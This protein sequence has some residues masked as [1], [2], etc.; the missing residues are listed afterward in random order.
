MYAI[1]RRW[2]RQ[3]EPTQ[4]GCSQIEDRPGLLWA[5][6]PATRK[7]QHAWSRGRL[8][9]RATVKRMS[10]SVTLRAK[11]LAVQARRQRV[12]VS[13]TA[14]DDAGESVSKGGAQERSWP[15]HECTGRSLCLWPTGARLT[16]RFGTAF[17]LR[18][19]VRSALGTSRRT[20]VE[21]AVRQTTAQG[22]HARLP[23]A[24]TTQ[25]NP[26]SDRQ[27]ARRASKRITEHR[28]GICACKLSVHAG[29]L[30]RVS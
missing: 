6:A 25:T 23:S 20:V 11:R 30:P 21:W 10:C 18:G 26:P 27:F 17:N 9:T 29:T 4:A 7:N 28:A 19:T 1:R 3:T 14:T 12:L 8:W 2:T 22:R 16:A 5:P 13:M 15:T 24:S